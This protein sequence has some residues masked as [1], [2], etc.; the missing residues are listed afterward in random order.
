MSATRRRFATATRPWVLCAA[1]WL[2]AAA[3]AGAE[4]PVNT[5]T[6]GD[7]GS[8]ATPPQVSRDPAGRFV[9]VWG[10]GIQEGP[11]L[12]LGVYG[13]RYDATGVASGGEL[14]INTTTTGDQRAPAVAV[15]DNGDF[16]VAW[17]DSAIPPVVHGADGSSIGVFGQLYSSAGAPIGSQ[18]PI[19]QT[20]SQSQDQ[21]SVAAVGT[22]SIVV[23]RSL[24]FAPFPTIIQNIYGRRYSAAGAP[25]TDEFLINSTVGGLNNEPEIAG[26]PAGEF[27]VVWQ[28]SAGGLSQGIFG[29][30]FDALGVAQGLEFPINTT[31]PFGFL[32]HP[33]VEMDDDGGFVVAWQVNGNIAGWDVYARRYDPAGTPEGDQFPINTNS[34]LGEQ[35]RPDVAVD[36]D[37]DFAVAWTTL[38][39]GA[40]CNVHDGS[41][42][43]VVMRRYTSSGDPEAQEFVV[44]TFTTGGQDDPSVAMSLNLDTVVVWSSNGQDGSGYGV[45]GERYIP[46]LFEDGFESGDTG[47]W[48]STEP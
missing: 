16:F 15:G 28:R 32:E 5:F 7:Q 12:G 4:F 21:P 13:Q 22:D 34:T 26:N 36:A 35:L 41:E 2:L 43:A 30:R 20:T 23:W 9:V 42:G 24:E 46:L 44:N 48:S 47:A 40:G 25:L 38:C 29:R 6:L 8:F 19:N 39:A 1:A 17:E 45:Y 14:H 18:I 11:G 3:T 37:G 31:N 33:A 10:S 27:V